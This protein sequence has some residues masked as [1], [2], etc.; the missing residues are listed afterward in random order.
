M[1]PSAESAP[2][3]IRV[4]DAHLTPKSSEAYQHSGQLMEHKTENLVNRKTGTARD[5]RTGERVP[6]G[7]KFAAHIILQIYDDDK[8]RKDLYLETIKNSLGLLEQAD[9]L[10]AAGSRGFGTVKLENLVMKTKP[11]SEIGVDFKAS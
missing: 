6:P 2:T 4:R 7:T 8:S 11:V 10:G 9:S 3:R 1:N 5:P